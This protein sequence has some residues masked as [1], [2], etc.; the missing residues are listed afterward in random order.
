MASFSFGISAI[1]VSKTFIF[2]S[3]FSISETIFCCSERGGSGI[4]YF[5]GS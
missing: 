4:L 2:A 3:I 1:S 5:N